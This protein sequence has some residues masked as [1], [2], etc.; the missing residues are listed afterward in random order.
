M[1]Y[2][3]WGQQ[4]FYL[5]DPIESSGEMKIHGSI[6]MIRQEKNKRLYNVKNTYAADDTASVTAIYEMP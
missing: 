5:K 2:T 4:V 1:G 3:H 6:E